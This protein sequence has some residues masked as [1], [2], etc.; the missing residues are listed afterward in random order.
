MLHER[1]PLSSAVL[2]QQFEEQSSE[3]EGEVLDRSPDLEARQDFWSIMGD[4]ICRNHVAPRTKL[5]VPKDDFSETS[6][7][8]FVQRQTNKN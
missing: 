3:E 4:Y 2:R 1:Q 7:L 8:F 5:H 6:E